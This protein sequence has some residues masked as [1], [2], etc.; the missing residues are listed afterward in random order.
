M[1][2][3]YFLLLLV[4]GQLGFAK[5][6]KVGS[7][8]TYTKPSQVST[9]VATGDTVEIDAGT[10]NSD[11][12]KW[13]ANNLFL[14]G[15]G[16]MAHLQANGNAYGGKAIWVIGGNNNR[17]ESIEFSLCNVVDKNG[18]G[19][20]LEGQNLAVSHC[21]FH[22]NENGILAGKINPCTILVEYTEFGFN[23]AGDG[24]SHNLYIGNIDTL[25]FQ[26]NYSHHASVG[27]ELK[28][29]ANVNFILYNKLS[30]E[31]TGNASRNIDL[32]NGGTAYIIGNVIEQGPQSQN[33]NIIGYGLEGL[34]N[35]APN[36]VYAI[37][38]TLINNK[39]NGSFFAFQTG[40]T[41]FKC[42]NN[43]LAGAGSFVTG[44]FPSGIDTSNNRV[45]ATI[46]SFAF[47]NV[48]NYDF[49]ITA[50][51]TAVI[52]KG[53]NPGT[54]NSFS[55]SPVK[56][57]IHS[58]NTAA[59][60]SSGT[61]DIGAYEYCKSAGI[62]NSEIP[63]MILFPNPSHGKI[64]LQNTNSQLQ[65]ITIYNLLGLLIY[66]SELIDNKTELNLNLNSGV[67]IYHIKTKDGLVVK[68][69]LMMD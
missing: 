60:C 69:K 33:S 49:H 4:I 20:R 17:V 31:T 65:E 25:K 5:T 40:T 6:W 19:I 3:K 7:S 28:S 15:V 52:N 13:T 39:T 35:T 42:Y 10:Y 14:K 46:S 51:S 24:Y 62:A 37:N 38:N 58:N 54:A 2:N 30:D 29:R 66:D 9:L 23:G 36:E 21:Y 67:Y 11:V 18:A 57:Y 50:A 59:R 61:L 27:H 1:K 48:A 43:I 56:E 34:T 16:G 68:G 64:I 8:R 47:T 26:Y 12:A 63:E 41:L 44:S 22:N 45:S 32:P 53:K 55:L